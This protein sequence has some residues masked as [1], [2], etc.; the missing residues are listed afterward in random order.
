MS[1]GGTG[2]AV[3][4]C[5][6]RPPRDITRALKHALLVLKRCRRHPGSAQTHGGGGGGV[7]GAYYLDIH[8]RTVPSSA[9]PA[10]GAGA[11][12]FPGGTG[13]CRVVLMVA[14][15]WSLGNDASPAA[16]EPHGAG[17]EAELRTPPPQTT[18]ETSSV[19]V[20]GDLGRPSLPRATTLVM[21]DLRA[22]KAELMVATFG[23][24]VQA[25]PWLRSTRFQILIVKR[26]TVLST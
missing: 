14:G 13:R 22:A 21:D 6:E 9:G 2:D 18:V 16:G 4:S 25:Q 10:R 26:M 24:A 20:P 15:E 17:G 7:Q 3:T 23:R 12:R 19:P 11:R 8:G 5:E 1:R